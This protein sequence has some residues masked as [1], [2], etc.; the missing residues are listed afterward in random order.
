MKRIELVLLLSIFLSCGQP[1][2]SDKELGFQIFVK[3]PKKFGYV[4]SKKL[5]IKIILNE[6][7]T[8]EEGIYAKVMLKNDSKVNKK[9]SIPL[10]LLNS[11]YLVIIDEKNNYMAERY[12]YS[13][14]NY[15]AKYNLKAG[16]SVNSYIIED[17]SDFFVLKPG[18]YKALLYY[19]GEGS[20]KDRYYS[21]S[22]TLW[23]TLI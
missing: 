16:D 3:N 10:S 13:L 22:D 21:I 8:I 17:I 11:A 14:N 1:K 18:K 20:E 5:S 12:H 23:F 4:E 6:K 15:N 19:L 2:N 7:Y 9:I